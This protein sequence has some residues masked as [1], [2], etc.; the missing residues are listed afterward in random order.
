MDP[1]L[2]TSRPLEPKANQKQVLRPPRR[3][4]NHPK[5]R[6]EIIPKAAKVNPVDRGFQ[7]EL[8]TEQQLFRGTPL[9]AKSSKVTCLPTKSS[10]AELRPTKHTEHTDTFPTQ[11]VLL[12]AH[13]L[14]A[15]GA[16]MTVVELT[17]S[18]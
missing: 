13:L 14:H 18:K 4:P 3:L 9:H 17:P 5:A 2:P 6:P 11:E 12:R 8:K 10:F 1:K 15:P 16:R 7:S